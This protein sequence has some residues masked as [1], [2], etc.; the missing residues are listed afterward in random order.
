MDN[1]ERE[2]TVG[3]RRPP[4]STRFKKGQSGNPAGRP[5]ARRQQPPYGSV[6]GQTFKILE[7]SVERQVTA[8]ELLYLKLAKLG[9]E[10]DTGASRV[11]LALIKQVRGE[12]QADEQ[13]NIVIVSVAP[14][15]VTSGL[16]ILH[17]ATKLDP[18][19]ETA[20]MALELWV[21]EAALERLLE[22]FTPEQQ[23][24]VVEATR[25]AKKVRWPDWWTE[26]P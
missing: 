19:R 4:I 24:I 13:V 11:L 15:S 6:L 1:I 14:G 9:L 10:G 22:P 18:Y 17:M 12:Q 16:E 21:V 26:F 20:R 5:P 25:T 7:S 8:T 23:R 3:Y 2:S